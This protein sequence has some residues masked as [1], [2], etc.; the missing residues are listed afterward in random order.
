MS[1]GE[2]SNPVRPVSFSVSRLVLC[3][4]CELHRWGMKQHAHTHTREDRRGEEK[5][6]GEKMPYLSM[7]LQWAYKYIYSIYRGWLNIG[8]KRKGERKEK[9]KKKKKAR[10]QIAVVRS[11]LPSAVCACC[12]S[13]SRRPGLTVPP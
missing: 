5:R 10:S 9:K 12:R 2:G 6:D 11:S 1:E 7:G 3:I 13:R 4:L 8:E